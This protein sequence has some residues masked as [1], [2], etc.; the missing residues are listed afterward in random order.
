[1]RIEIPF[2][3]FGS[4]LIATSAA[5]ETQKKEILDNLACTLTAW[6]ATEKQQ[7]FVWTTPK[8]WWQ[9]FKRDYF[10]KW[11]LEK[12]PIKTDRH[13]VSVKTVYPHLKTK[14]PSKIHGDRILV[15]VNELPVGTFVEGTPGFTPL[16]EHR[17]H[18]ELFSK[19]LS[20]YCFNCHQRIQ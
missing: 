7:P 15:M 13:E 18:E 10:P 19:Q 14:L 12:Y 20:D 17:Y 16:E 9:M 4:H 5:F 3:K 8:T 11:L 1:M 2:E 6:I